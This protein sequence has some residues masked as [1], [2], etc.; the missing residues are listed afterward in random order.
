MAPAPVIASA[1]DAD[2]GPQVLPLA[3]DDLVLPGLTSKVDYDGALVLP[4]ADAEG[5]KV[6]APQVLPV[7]DTGPVS[8]DDAG[9]QVLPGLDDD[10][11]VVLSKTA[12]GPQVLPAAEAGPQVGPQVLPGLGED[13][14]ILDKAALDTTPL[15]L[16]Q[17]EDAV[18]DGVALKMAIWTDQG[19]ALFLPDTP[20]AEPVDALNPENDWGWA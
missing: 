1:D 20:G 4:G 12:A 19:H 5:G 7:E 6:A 13:D 18:S 2:T 16:P 14:F 3:E 10:D 9:P 8:K 17:A 11:F 15:V